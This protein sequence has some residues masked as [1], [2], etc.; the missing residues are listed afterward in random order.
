MCRQPETLKPETLK[1]L[2]LYF[3]HGRQAVHFDLQIFWHK[4]DVRHG[5]FQFFALYPHDFG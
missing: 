2:F 1:Q 3:C 4:N 5:F